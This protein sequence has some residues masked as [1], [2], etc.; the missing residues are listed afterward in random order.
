LT[1]FPPES[2]GK[3]ADPFHFACIIVNMNCAADLAR[4]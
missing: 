2:R 3:L 4:P 1:S